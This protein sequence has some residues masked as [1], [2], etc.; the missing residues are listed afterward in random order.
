M[1]EEASVFPRYHAS[2]F[3]LNLDEKEIGGG[4]PTL[5]FTHHVSRFTRTVLRQQLQ[6][7]LRSLKHQV[8]L[9]T[10]KSAGG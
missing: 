3:S 5:P 2:V 9:H 7:H 8:S 10:Q 6:L 1:C 4:F